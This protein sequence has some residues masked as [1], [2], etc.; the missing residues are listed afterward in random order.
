[1]IEQAERKPNEPKVRQVCGLNPFLPFSTYIADGEPKVFGDR[2]YLY[3]SYDLF[4]GS[5]CSKEY[6]VMSAPVSDLTDWTDHGVSFR[7]QD[8]PW[9]DAILYAPDVLFHGGKYYLYFCLSDGSE[10]VAESSF[11]EGPFTNARRITLGGEP[12]TGID[13]SVIEYDGRIYYTWGQFSLRMGELN[14]DLCSLKPGT[15][16]EDVLSNAP[17][18]EGFHEGSSLRRIGDKW[19]MIYAS[20]Y[21]PEHPNSGSRPT[22]LDYAVSDSPYGPYERRGTVID[23]DGCDPSTWNNH[24]SVIKIGDGWYV[25]YHASSDNSQASRRARAEKLVVDESVCDIRQAKPTTNGF[26]TVLRPEHITSPVNACSFFGGAYVTEKEDGSFPATGLKNG[27]GFCFSPI[28]FAK[29]NYRMAV[30]Y[31]AAQDARLV[32]SLGDRVAARLRLSQSDGE[33]EAQCR[34]SSDGGSFPLRMEVQ[35]PPDSWLC[36]IDAIEIN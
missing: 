11:P 15:V 19:C 31:R 20:E 28:N 33:K 10:G 1:M 4:G 2:V 23:N 27:A 25:F 8:V 32:I 29:G 6:H 9:S 7:T 24:G 16:R 34:F 35:G 17:G 14:G 36:E 21:K 18:R 22:K 13:P 26:V 3:G 12:I 5:Y 30:S